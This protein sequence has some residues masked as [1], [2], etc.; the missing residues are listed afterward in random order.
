VTREDSGKISPAFDPLLA[1]GGPDMRFDAIVLLRAE[2]ELGPAIS[3]RRHRRSQRARLNR[4]R[5]IARAQ[6][7]A[8]EETVAD[9]RRSLGG[10][11]GELRAHG[12]GSGAL[13]LA[14]VEVTP[15]TIGSLAANPNVL[16]ILPNQR[17]ELIQPAK[18]ALDPPS[19]A[20]RKKGLTWGLEALEAPRLWEWAKGE[21]VTVAVLDTGVHDAHPA[22]TGRVRGFLAFDPL[23]RRIKVEPA[24]DGDEHGTHVCGTV[25]GGTT[26]DGVA[27]RLREAGLDPLWV[28]L[29]PPGGEVRVAKTI[30]PGLEVETASYGRIGARNLRRMLLHHPGLVGTE[31]PP[32][33]ARRILLPEKDLQELGPE[34][35][36]DVAALNRGV[37]R[38]Y[39]LY[40]EPSRHVAAL[41]ADGVLV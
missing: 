22:L 27:A 10:A 38:L 2:D 9:Y 7:A 8:Q 39:P 3:P 36:L 26:A 16:A 4:V 1:S 34:P 18:E 35:W 15:A 21:G 17:I 29:S 24:F 20:E 25:A 6:A 23:G 32:P 31:N 19:E 13:P 41:V 33:G 14:R 5:V 30:V 37:G 40:R 28:D 12:L 11:E